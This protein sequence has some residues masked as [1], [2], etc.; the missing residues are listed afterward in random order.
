M[1][2][3]RNAFLMLFDCAQ[4]R[5]VKYLRSIIDQVSSSGDVFQLVL[6][7]LLRKM[8]KTNPSEKSKYLRVISSLM[9]SK[10]NAVVYQ[11]AGTLFAVSASS[12]AIKAAASCYIRLLLSVR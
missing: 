9:E 7:N 10:T 8:C 1:S 11:C 2:S 5:A 12:A 6:L 3:K 4:D